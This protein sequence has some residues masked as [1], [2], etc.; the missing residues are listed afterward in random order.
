MRR[1][2]SYLIN[3]ATKSFPTYAAEQRAQ[4]QGLSSFRSNAMFSFDIQ[5]KVKSVRGVR[6]GWERVYREVR[7]K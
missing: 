4:P 7:N 1:K 6:G 2:K 5:W 3:A